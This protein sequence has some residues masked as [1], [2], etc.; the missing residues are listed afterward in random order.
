VWQW[1]IPLVGAATVFCGVLLITPPGFTALP[2]VLLNTARGPGAEAATY[3][4]GAAA[5]FAL[6]VLITLSGVCFVIGLLRR[7]A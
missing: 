2:D 4:L 1:F 5:T 7:R 6:A 3:A